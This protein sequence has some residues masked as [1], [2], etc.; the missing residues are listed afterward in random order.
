L[1]ALVLTSLVAAVLTIAATSADANAQVTGKTVEQSRSLD[2]VHVELWS[3]TQR[4]AHRVTDRQGEFR[5]NASEVVGAIAIAARRIGYSPARVPIVA[6]GVEYVIELHPLGAPLPLVTSR[7]ARRVCPNVEDR[8]A[9]F[10]WTSATRKYRSFGADT[11][12][13]GTE[14]RH[15]SG[16][17]RE[18][19][20]GLV[21]S[22]RITRASRSATAEVME[23]SRQILA[24][25]GY[26]RLMTNN[27]WEPDWGIWAYTRLESD[28]ASHFAE[29]LFASRH[30]LSVVAADTSEIVLGFCPRAPRETGLEG[31][32]R[33]G[34]D[35]SFLAVRWGYWNPHRNRESAGGEVFFLP[36]GLSASG[37]PV[38]LLP[39]SGLF[40]RKL[41]NGRYWQ[42]W[43]EY[44][45]WILSPSGRR[46]SGADSARGQTRRPFSPDPEIESGNTLTASLTSEEPVKGR[47][48][49]VERVGRALIRSTRG[50]T[51]G[52]QRTWRGAAVEGG[53]G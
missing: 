14:V 27:H 36:P 1:R 37:H 12:G 18:D 13:R 50:A 51:L 39:A 17:V 7:A 43:E 46:E 33:L 25:R 21:D 52:G 42:R 4:L 19:S 45:R 41:L 29:P 20:L 9:R 3:A 23:R 38:P 16:H 15:F 30:V 2:N 49:G 40:W 11:L 32:L 35:T 10:L 8:V 53:D 6:H 48:L 5:F 22:A 26:V 34:V 44:D 24:A 28:Y 31:T 47:A